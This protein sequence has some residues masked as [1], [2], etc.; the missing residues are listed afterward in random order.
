M[1]LSS[2]AL[3]PF[4]LLM[5][6][7]GT[8]ADRSLLLPRNVRFALS[9]RKAPVTSRPSGRLRRFWLMPVC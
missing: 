4:K 3:L 7:H 2:V 5:S 6:R 9:P 8:M 1:E